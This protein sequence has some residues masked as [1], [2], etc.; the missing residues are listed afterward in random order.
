MPEFVGADAPGFDALTSRVK[1]DAAV[2]EMQRLCADKVQAV[3][4]PLLERLINGA[5]GPASSGQWL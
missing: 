1:R 3:V 2:L 5:L 4:L